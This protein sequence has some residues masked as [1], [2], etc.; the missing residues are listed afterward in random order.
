MTFL[1][2]EK[3]HEHL[4]REIATSED[5]KYSGSIQPQSM[6]KKKRRLMPLDLDTSSP[7]RGV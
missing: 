7:K 5:I 3:I 4:G 6:N 1:Q 2:E